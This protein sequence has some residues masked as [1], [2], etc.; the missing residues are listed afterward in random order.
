MKSIYIPVA[1]LLIGIGLLLGPQ[2]IDISNDW[3][4][5]VNP[6]NWFDKGP[7]TVLIVEE[8]KERTS[9]ATKEQIV[10][11]SS[12][13]L[14]KEIAATGGT[15]LGIVDKDLADR[16]DTSPDLLP[17]LE[18]AKAVKLPALVFKHKNK[19]KAVSLPQ[20]EKAV[21]EAIR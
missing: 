9:T 4:D 10:V 19:I 14:A 1:L 15:F 2:K 13:T 8:T 18:A 21:M 3:I 11:L 5:Y 16:K 20:S 6:M 7:A 12:P 17:Y